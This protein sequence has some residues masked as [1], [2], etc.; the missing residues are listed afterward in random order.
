MTNRHQRHA[1]R[2]RGV[3]VTDFGHLDP[4]NRNYGLPV[5]CYV[6]GA[7]H[8]AFGLARIQG[9]STIDVP[10]CEAC[11]ESDERGNDV[12][13]KYLNA[14]DLK[15]NEGGEAT[16]EQLIAMADKQDTTEH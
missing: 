4:R 2:K 12:I 13:R 9:Q 6:C 11:L 8:K 15:I 1:A 3:I 10:L 7:A 14:P 5:N 16:T